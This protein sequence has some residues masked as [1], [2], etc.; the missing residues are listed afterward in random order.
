MRIT[1]RKPRPLLQATS[2]HV[3]QVSCFHIEPH[4]FHLLFFEPY[5]EETVVDD[6]VA[7]IFIDKFPVEQGLEGQA[8]AAC[9]RE[10]VL[11]DE[12][13]REHGWH[14]AFLGYG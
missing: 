10:T 13:L 9:G 14:G 1:N 8:H 4:L 3:W 12:L 5:P 7:I 6:V 11:A 2:V